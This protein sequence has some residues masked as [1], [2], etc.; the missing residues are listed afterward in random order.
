MKGVLALLKTANRNIRFDLAGLDP[1]Q[2]T[3]AQLTQIKQTLS[4]RMRQF[5]QASKELLSGAQVSAWEIG[6]EVNDRPLESLGI[7]NFETSVTTDVLIA[8]QGMSSSLITGVTESAISKIKL[9]VDLAVLGAQSPFQTAQEIQSILGLKRKVGGGILKRVDDI[10]RTEISRTFSIANRMRLESWHRSDPRIEKEWHTNIDGRERTSHRDADGQTVQ[11]NKP[12]IV[13][14][15]ELMMPLDPSAPAKEV[16][17]CRCR[18]TAN[19]DRIIKDI[20]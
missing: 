10:Y 7:V 9:A 20:S 15:S 12:F 16:V 17:S 8:T 19:I 5:E 2:F 6:I 13:G 14:G 4:D 1:D 18:M 3:A 11:V